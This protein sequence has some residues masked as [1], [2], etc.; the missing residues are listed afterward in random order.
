[1][2][3]R[4]IVSSVG[5]LLSYF[6]A[7]FDHTS[8]KFGGGTKH[9]K[10]APRGSSDVF[11]TQ[12][13]NPKLA[14]TYVLCASRQ[15]GVLP[16]YYIVPKNIASKS[17]L[18]DLQL[19]GVI[20]KRIDWETNDSG[21]ANKYSGV[22]ITRM[23]LNDMRFRGAIP[24]RILTDAHKSSTSLAVANLLR[25]RKARMQFV[26]SGATQYTQFMD[27]RGGA[28]QALKNGGEKSIESVISRFYDQNQSTKYKRQFS[29]NGDIL[30]MKIW[31]VFSMV[32][33]AVKVHATANVVE[34]SWDAVGIDLLPDLSTLSA[35]SS[36]LKRAFL[37][38]PSTEQTDE[39]A[40]EI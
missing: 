19:K 5:K 33:E 20:P 15:Y 31:D 24:V 9:F 12:S 2:K 28:A 7:A 35:L 18:T 29:T 32:E 21:W 30:L 36:G 40:A 23:I 22:R 39:E 11:L 14:I 3:M 37:H 38:T 16:G 1:M 26:L 8:I 10:R 17:Q 27:I 25:E 13:N 6:E 34:R 4:E